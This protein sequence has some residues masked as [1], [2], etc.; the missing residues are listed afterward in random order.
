MS[1]LVSGTGHWEGWQWETVNRDVD[2]IST[3]E[4]GSEEC[5]D[6]TE[7]SDSS[8]SAA[9]QEDDRTRRESLCS[10]LG[11]GWRKADLPDLENQMLSEKVED[12]FVRKFQTGSLVWAKVTGHSDPPWPARVTSVREMRGLELQYRVSFYGM[13]EYAVLEERELWPFISRSEERFRKPQFVSGGMKKRRKFIQALRDIEFEQQ[14]SGSSLP[15]FLTAVKRRKGFSPVSIV[16]NNPA[17]LSQDLNSNLRQT[18][19][20]NNSRHGK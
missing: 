9:N 11:P 7:G 2:E 8:E 17:S 18:V 3:E 5:T 16:V 1:M 6:I 10:A 15:R 19:N 13:G 14:K 4:G 12:E 20:R